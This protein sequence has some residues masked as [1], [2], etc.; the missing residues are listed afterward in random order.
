MKTLKQKT[1]SQKKSA[2]VRHWHHLDAKD[3]VLG[4]LAVEI[5]TLLMGKDKPTYTPHIDGGDYVVVTN[6]ALVAV[7]GQKTQQK[8][9]QHHSGFPGGFKQQTLGEMMKR[10]PNAVIRA[11]VNNMLPKN[12]LRD[13][14]L[15]RLKIFA[16]AE[17]TYANYL[18]KAEK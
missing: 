18:E 16:G 12:K 3:Q 10:Q 7:T 17:H 8:L 6:S 14:R 2:V 4:R 5:A 9:Y 11:A 15:A 1:Y 13:L